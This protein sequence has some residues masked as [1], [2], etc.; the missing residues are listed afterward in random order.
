MQNES[1]DGYFSQLISSNKIVFNIVDIYMHSKYYAN[2]T[3]LAGKIWGKEYCFPP[4]VKEKFLD[5][6]TASL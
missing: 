2:Q 1:R 4:S 6:T 5:F 3:L